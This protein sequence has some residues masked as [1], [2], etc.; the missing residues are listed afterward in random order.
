MKPW[1]INILIVIGLILLA[2]F[3][4]GIGSLAIFILALW[5]YGDSRKLQIW[6][7]E[8]TAAPWEYFFAVLLLAIVALPY[9][10]SKR[11]K[12]KN[13]KIPLRNGLTL[14]PVDDHSF[15]L[16]K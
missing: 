12:I 8:K 2:L 5:V 6:K 3:S 7:Y 1:Q 4:R 14:T 11:H 9:Y 13:G 15:R 16:G 10:I